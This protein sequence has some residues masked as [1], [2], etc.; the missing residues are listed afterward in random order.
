MLLVEAVRHAL[1]RALVR[2]LLN[3]RGE[4]K[5]V[6]LDRTI[7]EECTAPLN[8]Q[9]VNAASTAL[10]PTTARRVLEGLRTLFGEQVADAPAGAAVL[11]ARPFPSAPIAGTIFT[12]DCCAGA[13]RNSPAGT[14]AVSGFTGITN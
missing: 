8:A 6:T 3:E 5:V 12:Q 13:H 14:R 2:P 9:S 4:L 7:E 11:I 1:G 10:Q